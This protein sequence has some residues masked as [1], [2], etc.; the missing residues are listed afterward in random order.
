M[1]QPGLPMRIPDEGVRAFDLESVAAA[2]K[3][4]GLS[5]RTLYRYIHK[6]ALDSYY[7]GGRLM[8]HRRDVD[9]FIAGIRKAS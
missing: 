1:S 8:V 3:R 2:S 9:E 6:G 5:A 7:V 4:M